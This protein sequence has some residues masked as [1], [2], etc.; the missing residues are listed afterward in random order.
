MSLFRNAILIL[1]L[2]LLAACAARRGAVRSL[3]E[4]EIA[5]DGVKRN[6]FVYKPHDLE[7]AAPRPL[8]FVLHGGGGR[9]KQIARETGPKFHALAD[10]DGFVVVYPDA[11]DKMWDFGVGKVSNE[12]DV[13]VDDRAYFAALLDELP[14]RYKIDP[15]RI[16]ATGI[17]R[18][19]QASYF[20]AC[21]FPGKIRA[22]AAVAMPLPR[23]MREPCGDAPP[24]GVAILNGTDDPLVPYGGGEIRVFRKQRGAVHSTEETVAFWRARNACT[25]D[26]TSKRR[27]NPEADE[28]HVDRIAW[29][30]C[31][32]APVVLYTIEGGGHT[33]PSGSQYLPRRVIG[34]VTRDIDGAEEIWSFFKGFE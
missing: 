26:P 4:H 7:E 32:G 11:Y 34:R 9:G 23:F 29:T 28:T 18:G 3:S 22:I 27:I 17:S 10:R 2:C 6:Y 19:G 25:A 12:L 8:V 31:R 13:R 24:V 30:D 1:S 15:R 16:F 14:R 33:W 5:V 21:S 20:I